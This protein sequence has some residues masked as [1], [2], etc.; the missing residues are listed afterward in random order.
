MATQANTALAR[1]RTA[2]RRGLVTALA[3]V[4]FGLFTG[5]FREGPG[6][7]LHDTQDAVGGVVAPVQ[8]VAVAAIEPLQDGWNW[9]SELRG[10]RERA[11]ALEVEVRDL[12]L[13]A[14]NDR[15]SAQEAADL[16][17]LEAAGESF[18]AN[19]DRVL[20]SIDGRSPS[21]WYQSAR[22]DR[23]SADGI[24]ENSPVIGAGDALVG[25]VT[26]VRPH[27]ANVRFITD[28][29]T[30]VGAIVPEA[31]ELPGLVTSPNPGQLRL[32]GVPREADIEE[33]QVVMTGGFNS[34]S[35][36]S[37]YPRGLPI[38]VVSSVGSRDVDAEKAVQVKPLI[39]PRAEHHLVVL[40]PT[41]PEAI[42]RARG[43]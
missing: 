9:F 37:V 40:A 6:G 38:G 12:R 30:G 27:S 7:V 23:G 24:I 29:S 36:P 31:G 42:R 28:G 34:G 4:A 33:G 10:A 17:A 39:D 22:I 5:Y 8:G 41:S 1:R 2:L 35:L 13:Q 18:A 15:F 20:A 16:A 14:I 21:P 32:T 11:A 19:Y 26:A 43:G 3:L 25:V